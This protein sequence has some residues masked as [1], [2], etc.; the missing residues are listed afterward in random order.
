MYKMGAKL[1]PSKK[2]KRSILLFKKK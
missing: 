2:P 1:K